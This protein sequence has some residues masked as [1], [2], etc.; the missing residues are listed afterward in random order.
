[1]FS[2]TN[3][4]EGKDFLKVLKNNSCIFL[5]NNLIVSIDYDS[6]QMI[7]CLSSGSELTL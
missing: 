6:S 4:I 1:M 3:S 2:P 5:Q 7:E